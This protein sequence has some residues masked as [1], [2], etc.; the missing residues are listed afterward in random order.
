M[1]FK[2]LLT[3][4]FSEAG[5]NLARSGVQVHSPD[6]TSLIVFGELDCAVA[7]EAALHF[8]YDCKGSS[9]LKPCMLCTNVFNQKSPRPVVRLDPTNVSVDH[10]CTD[11]SL[12]VSATE[13]VMLAIMD[14]LK[15]AAPSLGHGEFVELE[16]RL[17]WKHSP[18]GV[19]GSP[20]VLSRELPSKIVCFDYAH[21]VFV[22]GVSN[23]NAGLYMDKLRR[24]P[25]P[26]NLLMGYVGKWQW[27][28]A[29]SGNISPKGAFSAARI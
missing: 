22:N 5:H 26:F 9:G 14:R 4:F 18:H 25:M 2:Y 16:R 27:P 8:M 6:A 21:V 11:P 20:Q 12:F 19:M 17:G 7:D 3:L 24:S 29:I 13:D 1:L 15:T 28:K 23:I 10:T